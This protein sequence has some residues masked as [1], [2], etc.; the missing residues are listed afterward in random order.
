[1]KFS[2]TSIKETLYCSL[3]HHKHIILEDRYQNVLLC[4]Y[5]QQQ[6]F[7]AAAV[8]RH[9]QKLQVS[10]S[11]SSASPLS[12][13]NIIVQSSS[14]NDLGAMGSCHEEANIL[15]PNGNPVGGTALYSPLGAS[16]P[17]HALTA[18]E[19]RGVHSFH[20]EGDTLFRPSQR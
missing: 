15:D 4:V 6:A 14:Q 7:N 3:V 18:D 20:S 17:G 13:P 16:Q 19:S 8:V 1:M 9:M 5:F 11:E 2:Q 12:M 10:H